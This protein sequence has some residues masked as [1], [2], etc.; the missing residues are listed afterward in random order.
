MAKSKVYKNSYIPWMR[1]ALHLASLADGCTSPNPLVGAV[2]LN[3]EGK[4]VGEGFH[5]CAGQPHAETKALLQAGNKACGGTMFVTLEPCCHQGR[6]PPCTEAIINSGIK[7]VVLAIEDPDP[8]VSGNGVSRL[9]EAGIEV[10]KGLLEEE[11]TFLNREFIFRVSTGR[12]WGILKWAMSV[13]GRIGLPNGESKWISGNQARDSVHRLRSKCDA[14]IIGGGTLRSDNPLL[15][16][17]GKSN[18]EPLRVVFSQSLS[19]PKV[20]NLWDTSIARTTI[21]FGPDADQAALED[22]PYEPKRLKLKSKNPGSLLESLA[23]EGC[24]RIL[25]ECGAKLATAAIKDNCVQELAVFISPKLLGGVSAMTP[26]SDFGFKSIS[27]TYDLNSV[28]FGLEGKDLIWK[29]LFK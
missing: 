21:A 29:L 27:T 2:I 10:M 18:P 11:A 14:V 15:T 17:R 8:R 20:A 7:R 12:P 26:L 22:I 5:S 25:W 19:L 13:D 9:K 6:T 28:S 23:L 24:N 1:R 16:S 4:L 3:S